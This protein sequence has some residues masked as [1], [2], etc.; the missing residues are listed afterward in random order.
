MRRACGVS[1]MLEEFFY[2][3]NWRAGIECYVSILLPFLLA[4]LV[5]GPLP[6]PSTFAPSDDMPPIAPC[7]YLRE[8]AMRSCS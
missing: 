1:I 6:E 5:L 8:L 2:G 3:G 7:T 4:F